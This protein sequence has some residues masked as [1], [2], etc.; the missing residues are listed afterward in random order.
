MT[1]RHEDAR[2]ADRRARL[3]RL[4]P[5]GGLLDAEGLAPLVEAYS[6][7]RVTEALQEAVGTLRRR[8]LDGADIDPD[9][10]IV[11]AEAERILERWAAP[12]LVRVVNATGVVLNTNLGRAPLPAAALERAGAIGGAYSNL[13]YDL[14][15]GGRGERYSHLEDVLARLTGA[16]AAIAVNNN[17][18][19]V[20]LVVD[21][22]ARG[23]EVVVSRGE[24]VEIGGSFRIPDVISASGAVL[25][26]VGTTNKTRKADFERAIGPETALLLKCHT[27]NFRMIGFTEAVSGAELAEVARA[28]GI[29]AVEDLGSGVLLDLRPFGLPHEPTVQEA[30]AA[31]LDLVTFSGDKLLG[32]PQAGIVVGRRALVDRLKKNPLLRALRL[33]KV[34]IALLEATFRLYLAPERAV[35][36]VPTLAMLA[37]RPAEL[38]PRAESLAARLGALGWAAVA[39]EATS[40]PGGGSLPGVEIP[41]W[42][43]RVEAD[44]VQ[45]LA[46]ALRLGSTPVIGRLADDALLLDVRTLLAGDE[47]RVVEAFRAIGSAGTGERPRE[48]AGMGERSGGEGGIPAPAG[49]A[50]GPG[51]GEPGTAA[52][53]ITG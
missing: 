33:D 52:G 9:P 30:V 25:K 45:A 20:L 35:R 11:R 50:H 36:E 12:R 8:I 4:P 16:E 28:A 1:T 24:L 23:R 29:P 53:G 46:D 38:R 31:G 15:A 26:E 51:R 22:L 17:A 49:T 44:S 10:Q 39:A 40:Q 43:V 13:E 42:V 41:T 3:R 18:A 21:T 19:A 37:A 48:S 6:R 2:Q 27:S 5:V 7:E 47:D 14:A 34:T 32:G